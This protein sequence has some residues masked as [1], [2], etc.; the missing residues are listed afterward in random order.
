MKEA[1]EKFL[2]FVLSFTL[3][4]L[5]VPE[6]ALAPPPT[7]ATAPLTRTSGAHH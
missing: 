3:T 5:E 7:G 6:K 4:S 2:F 1:A